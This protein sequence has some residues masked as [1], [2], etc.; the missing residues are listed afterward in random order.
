MRLPASLT[1][2]CIWCCELFTVELKGSIRNSWYLEH[3]L[4]QTCGKRCKSGLACWRNE[5]KRITC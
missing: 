1:L 3:H 2:R 5:R 4:P